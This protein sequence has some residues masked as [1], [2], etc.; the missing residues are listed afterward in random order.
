MHPPTF[1]SHELHGTHWRTDSATLSNPKTP[2]KDGHILHILRCGYCCL[3]FLSGQCCYGQP[4]LIS[5]SHLLIQQ[6][7]SI[8]NR[9]GV[10]NPDVFPTLGFP[11]RFGTLTATTRRPQ[12]LEL[13]NDDEYCQLYAYLP[14]LH[15]A[16]HALPR[17]CSPSDL[18]QGGTIYP[19]MSPERPSK[20]SYHTWSPFKQ[21]ASEIRQLFGLRI[22]VI[23]VEAQ[24]IHFKCRVGM[25]LTKN[26]DPR[27]R[28]IQVTLSLDGNLS[29]GP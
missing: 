12:F 21:R 26:F 23:V 27:I 7:T 5:Q 11:R 25:T 15:S 28:A 10:Q 19:S 2:K 3:L 18:N 24:D 1:I 14:H 9:F 16:L 29:L 6:T 20:H 4:L 17:T 8:L 22:L 13:L